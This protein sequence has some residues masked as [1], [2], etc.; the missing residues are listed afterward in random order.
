MSAGRYNIIIEQ[1][2]LFSL[3]LEVQNSDGSAMDLSGYSGR[4]KVR[5]DYDSSTVL[6][7]FTIGTL[8]TTGIFT[9]TIGATTTAA[10]TA[11]GAVYDIELVDFADSE[12]VIR[13]I[14]GKA[15][16]TPEATK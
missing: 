12:N 13:L 14:Q 7:S 6:A 3:P 4:G 10:M 8:D 1:G 15:T 2:A 5:T 9:A 11:G 16:I